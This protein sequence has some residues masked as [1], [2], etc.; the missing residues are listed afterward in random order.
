MDSIPGFRRS[1]GRGNG[2]SLQ[3]S[4]LE[5]PWA[6][7][8]G[9]LQSIGLQSHT[10]EVTQHARRHIYCILHTVSLQSCLLFVPLWTV[11]CQASLSMGFSRQ[12]CWS[13]SP[14]PS[15]GDVPYPGIE[16]A[17]FT[18]PALASGFFHQCHLGRY[19]LYINKY[20][21]SSSHVWMYELDHEEG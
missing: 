20:N 6:E 5:N 15:P 13:G 7:E 2:N 12:E 9:R 8:S 19:I 10:T 17:Y 14:F 21:F 3:Y 18:S 16:L 4:C 1:F 11:A